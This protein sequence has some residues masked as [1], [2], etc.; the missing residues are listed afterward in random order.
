MYYTIYFSF[1]YGY[2]SEVLNITKVALEMPSISIHKLT[3]QLTQASR[4]VNGKE[5]G[6][7]TADM[8]AFFYFPPLLPKCS[9]GIRDSPGP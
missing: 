4:T 9:G 7:S 5:P 3:K 1:G 6:Q 8:S 2:F